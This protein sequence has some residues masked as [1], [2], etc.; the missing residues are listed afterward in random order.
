MQWSSWSTIEEA[1]KRNGSFEDYG[2]YQVRI[3]NFEGEPR[4]VQRLVGADP[5][6]LVYV[7]RSGLRATGNGRTVANR[8]R[9]WLSVWHPGAALYEK[10]RPLLGDHGVEVRARFLSDERIVA[11]ETEEI[12]NYRRR[13]GELAPFNSINPGRWD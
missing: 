10:A 5:S 13:H 4:T 11:D 6:G 12:I 1:A 9:E 2:I 7:G 8:M 3:V